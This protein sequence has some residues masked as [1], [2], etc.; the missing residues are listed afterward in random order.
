MERTGATVTLKQGEGRGEGDCR[1]SH[2]FLKIEEGQIEVKSLRYFRTVR[3][4]A[5]RC[6]NVILFHTSDVC[7]WQNLK[8]C[9]FWFIWS[10]SI[11][12]PENAQLGFVGEFH[13]DCF[14]L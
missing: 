3:S 4:E 6:R 5:L 2:M 11:K 9:L 1:S 13:C 14:C 8:L 12:M 10:G 7:L